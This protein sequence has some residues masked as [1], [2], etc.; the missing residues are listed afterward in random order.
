M[1][2]CGMTGKK[3]KYFSIQPNE[4]QHGFLVIYER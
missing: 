4:S 3:L 2:N 1:L